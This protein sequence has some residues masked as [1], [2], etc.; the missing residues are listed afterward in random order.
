MIQKVLSALGHLEASSSMCNESEFFDL[1]S[2]EDV[3]LSLVPVVS[4]PVVASCDFVRCNASLC[5]EGFVECD[6]DVSVRFQFSTF[7][8]CSSNSIHQ[9]NL[10]A[11]SWQ[12]WSGWNKKWDELEGEKTNW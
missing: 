3:C 11:G 9:P 4:R 8:N 1:G 12:E 2:D 7:T 6:V 5:D 10:A